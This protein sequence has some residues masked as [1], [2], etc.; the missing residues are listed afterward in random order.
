MLDLEIKLC[1]YYVKEGTKY[2]YR[3]GTSFF[4]IPIIA[5]CISAN[6]ESSVCGDPVSIGC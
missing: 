5:V 3:P 4:F 6:T 1:R 2:A